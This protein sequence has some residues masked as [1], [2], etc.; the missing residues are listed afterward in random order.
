MPIPVWEVLEGTANAVAGQE[1]KPYNELVNLSGQ[2]LDLVGT[3]KE[4]A[5]IIHRMNCRPSF[6]PLEY[7]AEASDNFNYEDWLNGLGAKGW[8]LCAIDPEGGHVFCRRRSE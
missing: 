8:R 6:A 3:M 5:E 2:P 4:C 1:H 7:L